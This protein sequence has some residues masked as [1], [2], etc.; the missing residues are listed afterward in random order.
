MASQA[1]GF[2]LPLM[3]AAQHDLPILA[4]D[5]PV[6]KELG[7]SH[8]SYFSAHEGQALAI[9]LRDW[10]HDIT[11]GLAPRSHGIERLSWQTSAQQLLEEIL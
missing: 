1:E 2:G 4:R 9:Q 11:H 6:F 5:I 10:M 7:G 8:V 3:E